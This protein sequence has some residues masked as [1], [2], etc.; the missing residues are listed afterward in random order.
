MNDWG[1]T[2]KLLAELSGTERDIRR[3]EYV[4]YLQGAAWAIRRGIALELA[5]GRCAVC[6]TDDGLDVHHRTYERF[7]NESIADLTVLCRTCHTLFHTRQAHEASRRDQ[8]R[9]L[10]RM[11]GETL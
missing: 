1:K 2:A 4:A 8:L 7:G 10:A 9:E 5:M 3:E 6:N 11:K